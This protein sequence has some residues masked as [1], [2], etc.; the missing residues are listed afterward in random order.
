MAD[1]ELRSMACFSRDNY[2]ALCTG[3][4]MVGRAWKI[5]SSDIRNIAVCS[6]LGGRDALASRP[7]ADAQGSSN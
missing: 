1:K 6:G 3:G 2:Q 5:L 4:A 7:K